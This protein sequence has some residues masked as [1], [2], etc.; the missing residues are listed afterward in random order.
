MTPATLARSADTNRGTLHRRR[1]VRPRASAPVVDPAAYCTVTSPGGV[2]G[3]VPPRAPSL[4]RICPPPSNPGMT[5][6]ER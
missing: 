5:H 6:G 4:S 1:D 3:G 2:G